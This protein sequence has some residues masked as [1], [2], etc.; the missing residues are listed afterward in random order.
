MDYEQ[1][2]READVEIL[3]ELFKSSKEPLDN[4]VN[5]NGDAALDSLYRQA[6]EVAEEQGWLVP[7]RAEFEEQYMKEIEKLSRHEV[8]NA[9]P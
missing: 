5:G 8:P 9:P 1:L 2:G 6:V 3:L 7:S 4:F